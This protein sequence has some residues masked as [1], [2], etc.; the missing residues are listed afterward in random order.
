M[1]EFNRANDNNIY[2]GQ[3]RR[4]TSERAH[5]YGEFP[6]A[7]IID[8]RTQSEIAQAVLDG[9][10]AAMQARREVEGRHKKLNQQSS[11]INDK[12]DIS[13]DITADFPKN[14]LGD[15]QN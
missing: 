2:D 9:A 11:D 3:G 12:P 5:I 7:K 6:L 10:R 13:S 4:R 8:D 15:N 1:N 14:H